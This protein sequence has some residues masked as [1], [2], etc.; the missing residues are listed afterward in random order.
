[1]SKKNYTKRQKQSFWNMHLTSTISISLVLFLIGLTCLLLLGAND[2]SRHIK[3]NIKLSVVLDNGIEDSYMKRIER[4]FTMSPYAKSVEYI[5]KEKAL[6]E[7]ISSLGEDPRDVLGHN[8]LMASIEVK[9]NAEYANN[10]SVAMI[11]GKLKTFD[12]INRVVY[13]KDMIGFV[14]EN[15]RKVS[16]ALLAVALILLI[17]SIALINNTV[18]LSIYSNRFLINTMKLVGATP[19]FIRKPYIRKSIW[20][21]IIASLLAIGYLAIVVYYARERFGFEGLTIAPLTIAVVCGTVII[22]GIFITGFSSYMAVGRYIRMNT[23]DMY[24][25]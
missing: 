23:N 11:E 17:I 25:V 2:M 4:Y 14:N 3:E 18:R 9:L 20:N 19:W 12:H 5:S 15:V 16:I 13:Q 1:M 10:D 7:L 22:T 6:D 24:F 8:P 21:G